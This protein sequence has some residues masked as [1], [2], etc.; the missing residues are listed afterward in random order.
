MSIDA[1]LSAMTGEPV[2][3]ICGSLYLA[4]H[5]LALIERI[6]RGRAPRQAHGFSALTIR[7]TFKEEEC[8]AKNYM[9]RASG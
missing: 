4:G 2:I 5:V 3:L 1:A 7:K 8:R 9:P 6:D